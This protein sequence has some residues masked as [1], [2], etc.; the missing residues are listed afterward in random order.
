[1][2]AK[3]HALETPTI[4]IQIHE[5][6]IQTKKKYNAIANKATQVHPVVGGF[7]VGR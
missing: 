5:K 3:P 1:M 7:G 6:S 4:A 2:L